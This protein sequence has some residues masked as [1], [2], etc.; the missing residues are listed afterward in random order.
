MEPWDQGK[1]MQLSQY[2]LCILTVGKPVF[3][4]NPNTPYTTKPREYDISM[5][6]QKSNHHPSTQANRFSGVYTKTPSASFGSCV[7]GSISEYFFKGIGWK[8]SS[9]PKHF[10]Y[11]IIPFLPKTLLAAGIVGD[12]CSAGLRAKKLSPRD[13]TPKR[14]GHGVSPIHVG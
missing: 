4:T 10:F 2:V 6:F 13:P 1:L 12:S 5:D 9:H 11:H 7:L 3:L 14:E 8:H